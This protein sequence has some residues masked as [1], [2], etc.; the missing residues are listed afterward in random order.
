MIHI[1]GMVMEHYSNPF[2][3]GNVRHFKVTFISFSNGNRLLPWQRIQ[4][5]IEMTIYT[6]THTHIHVQPCINNA[7]FYAHTHA[8][9]VAASTGLKGVWSVLISCKQGPLSAPPSPGIFVRIK[10][11]SVAKHLSKFNLRE[12]TASRSSFLIENVPRS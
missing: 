4:D 12:T 7:S 11:K 1:F 5:D 10:F 9:T 3:R 2:I 8:A 6:H